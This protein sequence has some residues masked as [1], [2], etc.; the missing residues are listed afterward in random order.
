MVKE[1]VSEVERTW[2]LVLM[3]P[4]S[5]LQNHRRSDLVCAALLNVLDLCLTSSNLPG[6]GE[7]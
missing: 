3:T 5:L 7:E 2:H 1:I 4:K 6:V